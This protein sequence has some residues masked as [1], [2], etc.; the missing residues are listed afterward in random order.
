M[1]RRQLRDLL[2]HLLHAGV[3]LGGELLHRRLVERDVRLVGL[4][5]DVHCAAL[6]QR[7]AAGVIRES[8]LAVLHVDLL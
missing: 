5:E 1:I 3:E 7:R 6:D 4:V 2:L 8:V